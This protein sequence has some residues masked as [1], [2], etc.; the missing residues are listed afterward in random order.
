MKKNLL[1]LLLCLVQQGFTQS[2]PSFSS[3]LFQHPFSTI[4]VPFI[5]YNCGVYLVK[6]VIGN[7]QIDN[8]KFAW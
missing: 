7:N 3:V 5:G 1:I 2:N 4:S 6:I 8:F